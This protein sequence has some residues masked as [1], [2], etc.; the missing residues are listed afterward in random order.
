[1]PPKLKRRGAGFGKVSDYIDVTDLDAF[2][3]SPI[4]HFPRDVEKL[5]KNFT[6][7]CMCGSLDFK[8]WLHSNAYSVF[9]CRVCKRNIRFEFKFVKRKEV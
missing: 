5:P 7:Q 1:M 6:M 8:G 9:T 3:Y 2:F 4:A